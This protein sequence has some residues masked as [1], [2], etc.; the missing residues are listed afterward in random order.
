[1]LTHRL[2]NAAAVAVLAAFII[3]ATSAIIWKQHVVSTPVGIKGHRLDITQ[4]TGCAHD[5]WPCGCDWR[6]SAPLQRK[7]L[8]PALKGH[9]RML[10]QLLS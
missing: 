2:N 8:R 3:T 5:A 6:S 4:P 9:R 10:L 7:P 1:M